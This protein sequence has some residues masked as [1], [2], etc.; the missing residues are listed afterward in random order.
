MGGPFR[1]AGREFRRDLWGS[2]WSATRHSIGSWRSITSDGRPMWRGRSPGLPSAS[3]AGP[4]PGR[5][6]GCSSSCR[7]SALSLGWATRRGCSR[8]G[9][10][11]L[12]LA[13]R[14]ARV[15]DA[16]SGL[17]ALGSHV[18]LVA[19]TAGIGAMSAAA[20]TT[21]GFEYDGE[22]VAL[23]GMV[24]ALVKWGWEARGR[25][26]IL[27]T[28]AAGAAVALGASA[29]WAA[30]RG[31]R[32]GRRRDRVGTWFGAVVSVVMERMIPGRR[33]RAG[34]PSGRKA[35]LLDAPTLRASREPPQPLQRSGDGRRSNS[36]S[37]RR[38]A[39]EAVLAEM[40]EQV[41]RG[42]QDHEDQQ[43]PEGCPRKML[44]NAPTMIVRCMITSRPYG[45]IMTC[46]GERVRYSRR[47]T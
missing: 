24:A 15:V 41:D 35:D 2:V 38:R 34:V 43:G 45:W 3:S 47:P 22:L 13:G 5:S 4:S 37:P 9:A 29:G 8:C 42:L 44:T 23:V 7:C 26:Q 17:L 40:E 32:D 25:R 21:G 28:V 31:V 19:W 33:A 1:A 10:A 46:A 11:A 20:W 39:P 36:R 12:Y 16:P 14:P 18:N 30:G 27:W 6:P